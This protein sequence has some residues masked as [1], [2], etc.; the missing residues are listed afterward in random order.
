MVKNERQQ[1]EIEASEI[2]GWSE[3]KFYDYW[4]S[5]SLYLSISLTRE[6]IKDVF[7]CVWVIGQM[8]LPG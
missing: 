7:V 8:W 3:L 4:L 6:I 2:Q 5:I 1:L